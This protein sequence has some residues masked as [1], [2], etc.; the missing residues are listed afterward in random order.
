[1]SGFEV[2]G[3]VLGAIPI[4]VEAL[5]S[6]ADGVGRNLPCRAS[7]ANTAR[8]LQSKASSLM[9]KPTSRFNLR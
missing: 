8:Y 6:Y 9:K 1:M 7:R 5:K 4:L 2:A 3:V